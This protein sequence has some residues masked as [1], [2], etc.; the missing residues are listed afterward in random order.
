MTHQ[1][2]F[3]SMKKVS[4]T[5]SA[6]SDNLF[7]KKILLA[8]KLENEKDVKKKEAISNE[9]SD[10]ENKIL[11]NNK[12]HAEYF[13]KGNLIR[14][15]ITKS[16]I[17]RKKEQNKCW[18]ISLVS[19]EFVITGSGGLSVVGATVAPPAVAIGAGVITMVGGGLKIYRKY[20][21][22]LGNYLN[23]IAN[24]INKWDTRSTESSLDELKQA[25]KDMKTS[26]L[27]IMNN[28][29]FNAYS[30]DLAKVMEVKIEL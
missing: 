7:M 4:P 30:N 6:T 23:S 10:I 19:N 25:Y 12:K 24:I 14:E 29:N 16:F 5:K 26:C 15:I 13:K 20:T 2:S 28:S 17:E 21:T 9:I 22:D 11:Q 1:C 3:N 18:F 8:Q 27:S